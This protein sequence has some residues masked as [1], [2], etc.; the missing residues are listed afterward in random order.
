[1]RGARV[2]EANPRKG[3]H[4]TLAVQER[5]Q[6]KSH[7]WAKTFYK[8]V[9]KV[10]VTHTRQVSQAEGFAGGRGTNVVRSNQEASG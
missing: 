9:S 1:M 6:W 8:E 7:I 10:G 5:P 3:S 4:Q 2:A